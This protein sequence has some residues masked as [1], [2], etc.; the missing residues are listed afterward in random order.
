MLPGASGNRHQQEQSLMR[1]QR[2]QLRFSYRAIECS[3]ATAVY[4]ATAGV[5]SESV[6]CSRG[7]ERNSGDRSSRL[8][9]TIQ[10]KLA[11]T[12]VSRERDGALE[13]HP[14]LFMAPELLEQVAPDAWQ[15]VII[16][17]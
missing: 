11:L 13:L 2:M 7:K 16:R 14:R 12:R 9:R 17:K 4:P 3:E 10:Q 1:A 6:P 5:S 15:E 8:R